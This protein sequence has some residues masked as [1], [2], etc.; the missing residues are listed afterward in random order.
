MVTEL[1]APAG[2]GS[3]TLKTRLALSSV[4]PANQELLS[5]LNYPPPGTGIQQGPIS[6]M[7][8]HQSPCVLLPVLAWNPTPQS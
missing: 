5:V 7:V 1:L 4:W 2:P 3:L 6:E 8:G